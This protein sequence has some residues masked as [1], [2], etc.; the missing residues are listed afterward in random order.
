MAGK[1]QFRK[2]RYLEQHWW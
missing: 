1:G 2:F